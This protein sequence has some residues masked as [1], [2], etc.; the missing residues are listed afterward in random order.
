MALACP[1]LATAF[2]ATA[3]EAGVTV[4]KEPLKLGFNP[5]DL[6]SPANFATAL[7]DQQ[8]KT[9]AI[10]DFCA[11]VAKQYKVYKWSDDPCGQ[12]PWQVDL[13]TKGGNPLVYAQFG[14]GEETTILLGGVHADEL[15]PV[16]LA[17]RAARFLQENKGIF[18]PKAVKIIVAPLVNP[19]GFLKETASRNNLN[20]VDLNR[21]FFTLD[22]YAKAKKLWQE[23]RQSV[24][25]HFPGHFPNSEVETLF[26]I[27][28]IDR[29]QPDKILS[30][31][32]PLG[33]L[34]YDGPGDGTLA[35][36][37]PTQKRAKKLV[38]SIS[39][40]SK[41]Y[42]IVDYTFY[43]GSLG[44]FAGNERHIPTVTLELETMNPKMV[45][46]YWQQF[47]PGIVQAVNYH[48]V[49]KEEHD[50][51]RLLPF[52]AEYHDFAGTQF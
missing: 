38:Q 19:D 5:I 30:I 47:L 51:S 27:K 31:H 22:W 7:V 25:A 9:V 28:L 2:I 20:G 34:D 15:T 17:F 33:F 29:Y 46:I 50:G 35:N 26:Q 21:N 16:H 44:N 37:S 18:D 41:N 36:L 1:L 23:R 11:R 8:A 14:T 32:A 3:A 52:S 24:A 40:K 10:Q 42:K 39:E 12:V 6:F 13:K 48:Y 43:P 49:S 45:D 4:V